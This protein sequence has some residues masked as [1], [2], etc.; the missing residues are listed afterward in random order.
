MV[1]SLT[2]IST[3]VNQCRMKMGKVLTGVGD[4]VGSL[5]TIKNDKS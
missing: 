5:F 3:R 1:F 2:S 4:K